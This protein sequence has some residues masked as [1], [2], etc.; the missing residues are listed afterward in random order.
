MKKWKL[1]AAV[2]VAL[3][4]VTSIS[5]VADDSV[6]FHG[7]AMAAGDF[8]SE[9]NRPKSLAFHV[10][11][12]GPNQDPRGKMGDMGNTFW[13][14]YFAAIAMNKRWED[15]YKEGE[16]ADFTAQIAT[17][18]DKTVEAHQLYVQYGGMDFLPQGAR[19]WAGRKYGA[20]RVRVFA[21]NIR[22]VNV[23][24][25]VGYISDNFDLT[26][27]YNQVDWSDANDNN[28]SIL[29][30]EGSRNVFDFVYRVGNY[31]FGATYLKE[32][33]DPIHNDK[34]Q[35]ISVFGKYKFN[36]FLGM[37]G[38]SSLVLQGAKGVVAQYMNNGRLSVLSEEDDK[39]AR[40]TYY[41]TVNQFEGLIIEPA[42]MYEYTDRADE[43]RLY[44]IDDTMVGG[45]TYDFGN[46][47]EQGIFFGVGVHQALSDNLAMKYEAV[48]N[49]TKNKDGLAGVD[50]NM[51]KIAVGPALQ[52]KTL[53][54][55]AP[56]TNISLAYVGGDKELTRLDKSS[57]WRIGYRM[58]VFF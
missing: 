42:I 1:A 2:S 22:E 41:G 50:G 20:E 15:V 56:V 19:V 38:H 16:W 9:I 30:A 49:D 17:Y 33:D 55:V 4:A 51:Y 7:Y 28:N 48:F 40:V 36:S 18:G 46:A 29:A 21:Y 5:A 34:R 25:G 11:P 37:D 52:L 57:E 45:R 47:T 39:S 32:L 43:R 10:D 26:I 35:A 8:K 23:D 12:T 31:E 44:S 13:H 14:D 58:E 27:G 53:P 24:S 54:W 3:S 6:Q